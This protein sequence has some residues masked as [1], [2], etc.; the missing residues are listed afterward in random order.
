MNQLG[1]KRISYSKMLFTRKH[2]I[3][4]QGEI[5]DWFARFTAV[6][7]KKLKLL[8]TK[9]N[10]LCWY[11]EEPTVLPEDLN[12][13]PNMATLD[14]LV[15]Q[16]EGGTDSLNNLVCACSYC[17]SNRGTLDPLKYKRVASRLK[18]LRITRDERRAAKAA[19]KLAEKLEDPKKQLAT[20]RFFMALYFMSYDEQWSEVMN[21]EIARIDRMHAKSGKVG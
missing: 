1:T 2:P 9:Q 3:V 12:G 19:K 13:G 20:W 17:N 14:H 15:P 11:C 7:R 16:V 4:N 18:R 8:H 5:G 6:R 21:A 10:G